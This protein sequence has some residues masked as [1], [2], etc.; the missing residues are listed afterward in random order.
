MMGNKIK[1]LGC[2]FF[3]RAVS[4]SMNTTLTTLKLDHNPIGSEGLAQLARGLC[5]NST[6]TV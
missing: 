1:T 6:I 5:S 2:E 4:P 3:G